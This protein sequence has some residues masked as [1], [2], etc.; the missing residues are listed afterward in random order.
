MYYVFVSQ[1]LA[2]FKQIDGW[3]DKAQAHAEAKKFDVNVLMAGRLAADMKPF[4]YQ[5]QSASD[6]V[7]A[8]AGWLTGTKPPS[9]ADDEITID[10][11]RER[12]RKTIAFAESVPESAYAQTGDRLLT[13][14][15]KKG[16]VMVASDYLTQITVPN[17]FFHLAIGYAILR[18]QGVGLGKMDFLGSLNFIDPP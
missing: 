17:V 9:F 3:L 16:K 7:K 18:H 13:L 4:S 6:Y 15:W 10:Q 5:V 2:S 11:L 8:A 1:C 12:V 14:P